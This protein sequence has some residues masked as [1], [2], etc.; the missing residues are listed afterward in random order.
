M[1]DELKYPRVFALL[2][3]FDS[4]LYNG[5]LLYFYIVSPCYLLK[6]TKYYDKG[7]NVDTEYLVTFSRKN[8]I[9]LEEI[10]P[11]TEDLCFYED[12][13]SNLKKMIREIIPFSYGV[14]ETTDRVSNIFLSYEDAIRKRDEIN[15]KIFANEVLLFSMSKTN[16]G[17][18]EFE[19]K[20]E[21]Y[22]QKLNK[23]ESPDQV[24]K[25]TKTS[26]I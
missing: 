13:N 16:K 25:K 3:I 26:T 2:P 23:V 9:T 4:S 19:N 22:Q 12:N 10:V 21:Y 7:G 1:K 11:N 20:I 6:E 17:S 14:N 18:K 8:L 5:N 15:N 24:K